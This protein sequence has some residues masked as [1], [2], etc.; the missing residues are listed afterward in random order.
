MIVISLSQGTQP[1]RSA[2]VSDPRGQQAGFDGSQKDA[3][4]STLQA[5]VYIA[6][7]RL[8]TTQVG[9]LCSVSEVARHEVYRILHELID[10]DLVNRNLTS[11]TTY[12]AV[13]PERV[14]SL[15]IGK[16][17]QTLES[18]EGKRQTWLVYSNR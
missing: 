5:K 6:L 18:V 10:E 7:L 13:E 1:S 8:G 3:G 15:L 11:P 9:E 12:T 2:A 17:K 14:K 16:V 4:L